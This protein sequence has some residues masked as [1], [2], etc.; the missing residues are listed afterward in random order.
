MAQVAAE[1]TETVAPAQANPAPLGL[2][3]FALTTFVLSVFNTGLISG[4]S[5]A[6][7]GLA[8]FYGGLGQLLA[9]MWEFRGGNTFGGTAFSSYGAFWM[10]FGWAAQN[11]QLGNASLVG[12]F[13][14]GWAIFTFLMLLGTLRTNLA[15]I[16]V[17]LFLTLTFIA[18]AIS[19]FGG[20][21]LWGNIGGWLGVITAI[22][23]WYT[24]L[25]GVL[26]SARSAF[27][28]PIF[29]IG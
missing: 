24:A 10:A 14:L 13:M 9:G 19:F 12:V 23:A 15:L 29:P 28:L 22:L 1:N 4:T 21:S 25:A 26:S 2:S 20:G 11:N 7:I 27:T 8:L 18:L 3:A 17:F 6:V 5:A 16:G